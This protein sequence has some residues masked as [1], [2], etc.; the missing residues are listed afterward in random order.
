MRLFVTT[1]TRYN[2]SCITVSVPACPRCQCSEYDVPLL[3][4]QHPRL[5]NLI[6]KPWSD[7]DGTLSS[8]AR[9][10]FHFGTFGAETEAVS[11]HRRPSTVTK[12]HTYQLAYESLSGLR[13]RRN[14]GKHRGGCSWR[15]HSR[16]L[17]TMAAARRAQ[18]WRGGRW[19]GSAG[20]RRPNRPVCLEKYTTISCYVLLS[21]EWDDCI[22]N[23]ASII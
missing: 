16:R 2:Y 12:K 7:W 8:G 3:Q 21:H 20:Q 5:S 9:V 1:L 19:D 10:P 13:E 6:N 14:P 15:A 17:N 23:T 22:F 18:G 11:I 4:C